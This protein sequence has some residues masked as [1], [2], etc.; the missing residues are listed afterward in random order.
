MRRRLTPL[1]TAHPSIV[2]IAKKPKPP[3]SRLPGSERKEI[4][5]IG[6][7]DQLQNNKQLLLATIGLKM[8]I[9]FEHNN[10]IVSDIAI[11]HKPI[12][13]SF[14]INKTDLQCN[15]R[16]HRLFLIISTLHL[17]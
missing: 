6:Y 17:L 16:E 8:Y 7:L 13:N 15:I 5:I 11:G 2:S 1:A 12:I 3:N 10:I 4:A 14:I 9:Q